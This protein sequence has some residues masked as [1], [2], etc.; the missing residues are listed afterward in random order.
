MA[1]LEVPGFLARRLTETEQPMNPE[2]VIV[3]AHGSSF[4]ATLWQDVRYAA[5]SPSQ[6]SHVHTRVDTD[7]RTRHRR[8]DGD[9]QRRRRGDAAAAAVSRRRSSGADL[10]ERS[11]ARAARILGVAAEL[12]STSARGIRPSNEWSRPAGADAESDDG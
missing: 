5:R 9:L 8:D 10:G 12:P 2:P 4:V 6:E 3:G 1:E 7:A 11:A